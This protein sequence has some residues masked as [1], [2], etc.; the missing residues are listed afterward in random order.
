MSRC[1]FTELINGRRAEP[2]WSGEPLFELSFAAATAAFLYLAAIDHLLV[3]G[4]CGVVRAQP[5]ALDQLRALIEYSPAP[6]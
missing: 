1:P 4:R 2:S 6:R 5:G 3:G